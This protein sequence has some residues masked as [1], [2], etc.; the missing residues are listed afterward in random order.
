[1]QQHTAPD[2]TDIRHAISQHRY[3]HQP[4]ATSG[5]ARQQQQ[6]SAVMHQIMTAG[7]VPEGENRGIGR[8]VSIR[9]KQHNAVRV[10]IPD[11]MRLTRIPGRIFP[12][13]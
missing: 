8:W 5:P 9:V 6:A 3:T 10:G 11:G 7:H 13:A 12:Q 2:G 1:M 4:Q